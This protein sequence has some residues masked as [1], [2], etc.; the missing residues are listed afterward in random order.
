[1]IWLMFF[2]VCVLKCILLVIDLWD[3]DMSCSDGFL[4]CGVVISGV[5]LVVL[6]FLGDGMLRFF[7]IRVYCLLKMFLM[8]RCSC[9]VFGCRKCVNFRGMVLV[10]VVV[11][12]LKW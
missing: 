10:V 1:M 5:F 12:F 6:W 8:C 4:V 9:V 3:G 7:L 11:G 2:L